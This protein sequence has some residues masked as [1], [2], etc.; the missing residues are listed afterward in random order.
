MTNI[1][2]LKEIRSERVHLFY[3]KLI[4]TITVR[5]YLKSDFFFFSDYM[6][7]LFLYTT[8]G[9]WPLKVLIF[10]RTIQKILKREK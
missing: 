7:K 10:N 3:I 1:N 6:N 8:L 4:K 2:K 5:K 9:P